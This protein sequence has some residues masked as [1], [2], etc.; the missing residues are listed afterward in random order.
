[1]N[2][3]ILGNPLLALKAVY[4]VLLVAR[5]TSLQYRASAAERG[6]LYM[7]A[8]YK[9]WLFVSSGIMVPDVEV[10]DMA[11]IPDILIWG[12]TACNNRCRHSWQSSH[13]CAG[14]CS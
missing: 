9:G 14:D 4:P 3:S 12:F 1:M 2:Q 7:M 6:S 5:A 8:L 10:T 11:F 13:H